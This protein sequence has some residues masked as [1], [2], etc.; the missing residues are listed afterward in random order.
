MGSL[1]KQLGHT[2][3]ARGSYLNRRMPRVGRSIIFLT[4]P[5]IMCGVML[6]A[7][8]IANASVLSKGPSLSQLENYVSLSASISRAPDLTST[9]PPLQDDVSDGLTLTMKKPCYSVDSAKLPSKPQSQCLWGDKSGSKSI[10]LFGDSQ[11]A[12]WL[13]TVNLIGQAEGYKVYFLAEASCPPWEPSGEKNFALT[14]GLTSDQCTN[15]VSSEIHLANTVHP[16][17]IILAGDDNQTGPGQ[18]DSSTADYV[19][20]MSTLYSRLKPSGSKIV[21]LSEVPQYDVTTSNPMTPTDCLTVHGSDIL[22]CLLS[23]TQ[24]T[25]TTLSEGLVASSAKSGVPLINVLPLFC[26]SKAC[27]LTVWTP[28]GVYLVHYDQYHMNKFY[29]AF[30]A[31]AFLQLLQAKVKI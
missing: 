29:S 7:P 1:K 17:V 18:F 4:L 6:A 26:G 28:G 10:F 14:T 8:S 30:I 2:S 21:L 31:N 5:V 12:T 25:A 20:E 3:G 22:P 9:I 24:V 19:Q 13:P 23:P 16:A 27:P 15:I 11:A